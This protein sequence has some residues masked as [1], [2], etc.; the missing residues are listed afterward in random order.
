MNGCPLL[1]PT[2][3]DEVISAGEVAACHQVAHHGWSQLLGG[4]VLDWKPLLHK[5]RLF[6][7]DILAVDRDAQVVLKPVD[8]VLTRHEPVLDN[9]EVVPT[10]HPGVCLFLD[11]GP[12]P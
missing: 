2:V 3:D 8:P 7:D 6:R 4:E 5:V 11:L 10:G 12:D 9:E 1:G